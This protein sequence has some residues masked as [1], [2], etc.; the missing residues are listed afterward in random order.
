[1]KNKTLD[2]IKNEVVSTLNQKYGYCGLA[3]S[4]NIAMIN[5]G[6]EAEN[7]IITIKD[8]SEIKAEKI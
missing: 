6:G 5:S 1:M 8:A 3:D 4:D 2:K 7:F